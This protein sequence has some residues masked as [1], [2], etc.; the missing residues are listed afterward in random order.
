MAGS[1]VDAQRAY[2]AR[3]Q[4]RSTITIIVVMLGL[5]GAF[6]YASSYFGSTAPGV[7][8]CTTIVPEVEPK[9]VD[10]SLNVY[11]ATT[12]RGLAATVAKIAA[13]RGFK[14]KAVA[15]DP[16][17]KTIKG[18][19]ELRHGRDGLASAK[20]VAKHLPGVALIN[21][22]REGDTVDLVLGNTFKALG[23]VPA[24]PTPTTTLRPCPTITITQ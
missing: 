1:D 15:N 16:L 22:K 5:A 23:P 11:N 10:I 6:Y 7:Q 21:D 24:K 18:V 12:K 2:H 9:P 17:K 20:V 4:R 3:R 8:P 14:V 13:E 19:G